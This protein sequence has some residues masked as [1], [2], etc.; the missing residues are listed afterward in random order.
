MRL[1]PGAKQP[2]RL[3]EWT[4]AA[5]GVAGTFLISLNSGYASHGFSCYLVSNLAW[6]HYAKVSQQ[7]GLLGMNLVYMGLTLNGLYQHILS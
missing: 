6:L 1:L 2:L 3:W 4:G 5:F 7:P